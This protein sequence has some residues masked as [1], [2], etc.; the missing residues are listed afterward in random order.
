MS[1]HQLHDRDW[2]SSSSG[3]APVPQESIL[4]IL[5]LYCGC[6]AKSRNMPSAIVDR[7]ML[8]RQT[9][10]TEMG[11]DIFRIQT[12]RGMISEYLLYITN[13]TNDNHSVQEVLMFISPR[14]IA[15]T[16]KILR[17]K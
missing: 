13:S 6:F 16:E 7:H 10:R 17:W 11:S 3:S 12:V 4:E 8:P 14:E 5:S 15:S 9:K 2:R 1:L